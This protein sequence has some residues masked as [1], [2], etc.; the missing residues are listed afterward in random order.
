MRFGVELDASGGLAEAVAIASLAEDLGYDSVAVSEHHGSAGAV[1]HPLVLLTAVAM[2]TERVRLIA[3]VILLPLHHPILVAEQAAMLQAL[4]RGRLTV[5]VGLGYAETD[6]ATFGVPRSERAG[7]MTEAL[8][9]LRRVLY[10]E[11]VVHDGNYWP[12]VRAHVRALLGE[13]AAP[14]LWGGGWTEAAIHRLAAHVDAWAAG[15]MVDFDKVADCYRSFATGYEAFQG[16]R[17]SE[18]P[19]SREMFCAPT[20]AAAVAVGGKS[21][22]QLYQ[23]TFMHWGHPLLGR[24]EREMSYEELAVNRFLIGTP[25]ECVDLISRLDALGVTH[26]SFRFRTPGVTWEDATDSLKLFAQKV[27]PHFV[28]K[29]THTV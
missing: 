21:V 24:E 28:R 29:P 1:A 5:G 20:H 9:L 23:T 7:R 15:A 22:F 11:R 8:G 17:P 18:F 3:Q 16:A 13:N 14:P 26:L 10:D 25:N 19:V 6:F 2:R 4:S 12:G 27:M